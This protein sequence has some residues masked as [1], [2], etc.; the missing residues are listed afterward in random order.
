MISIKQLQYALAVEQTL[1]FKKA[2]EHCHV[3]QSALSTALAELENNLGAQVFER[4]NKKVIVTPYGKQ[5]L[6]R[7]R[8]I[9]NEVDELQRLSSCQQE[10]LGAP[11]ALGIIP[12][13]APFL[14]PKLFPVLNE[15]YPNAKIKVIEEQSTVVVDRVRRGELDTAILALPFPHDGLLALEFWQEDF[16]CVVP[17]NNAYANLESISSQHVADVNLMLLKDGHCLKDHVLDVCKLPGVQANDFAATSL[18]TLVQMVQANLGA[19]L[20]PQMALDQLVHKNERLAAIRLAE[21]SPHRRIAMLVRPNYTRLHCIEVLAELS[22][23]AL[24]HVAATRVA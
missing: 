14:L 22:R 13:I 6:E 17:A 9:V 18:N 12:T 16:Y 3:S 11:I 5:V 8:R 4:N 10:P 19:T 21:E 24:G 23:S 1:H 2:A 15:L 20:I 7:A